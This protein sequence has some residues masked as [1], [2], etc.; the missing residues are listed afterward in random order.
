MDTLTTAHRMILE[1]ARD[2]ETLYDLRGRFAVSEYARHAQSAAAEAA[3]ECEDAGL[4]QF[5]RRD[6]QYVPFVLTPAGEAALAA[7]R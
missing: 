7:A 4:I 5:E 1:A 3:Q 6:L 2:T